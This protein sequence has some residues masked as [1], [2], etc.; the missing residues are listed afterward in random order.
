MKLRASVPVLTFNVSVSYLYMS[1]VGMPI[2]LQE[3][4][5]TDINRSEKHEC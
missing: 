4:M 3:N 1:M 2:L 5:C